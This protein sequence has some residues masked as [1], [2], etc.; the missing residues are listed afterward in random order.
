MFEDLIGGLGP[1]EGITAVVPA[2]DEGVDGGDT[3]L[4]AGEAAHG[5]WLGG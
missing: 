1:G 4:D 2:V 3:V 5:G